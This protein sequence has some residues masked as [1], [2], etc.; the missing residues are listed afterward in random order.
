MTR[1]YRIYDDLVHDPK[2]QRLEPSLFKTLINLW[3]LTSANG[4]VLPPVDEIAFKLRIN[5][6]KAQRTLDRLIAEALLDQDEP[7]IRPHN[8][9]QR[10]YKSD[11]STS[12]VK[13]FRDRF[14]N[15][16]KTPDVTAP[17]AEAEAERK[18]PSQGSMRSNGEAPVRV[19]GSRVPS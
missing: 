14:R 2:V 6:Q 19:N 11:D 3:C 12:R 5:P 18:T 8:W 16:A 17:E 9:N 4:G 1:W 15:V 10:Q 7:G 13:R